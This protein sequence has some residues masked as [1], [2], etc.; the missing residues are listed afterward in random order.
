MWAG[1]RGREEGCGFQI[2]AMPSLFCFHLF[3]FACCGDGLVVTPVALHY[4]M[5]REEPVSRKGKRVRGRV[6][7]WEGKGN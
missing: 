2:H 7:I 5:N 6:S 1:G 3:C 4:E